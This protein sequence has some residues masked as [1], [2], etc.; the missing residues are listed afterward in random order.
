MLK[1]TDTEF[2]SLNK[3]VLQNGSTAN[4]EWS[5][6]EL[7]VHLESRMCGMEELLLTLCSRL[8]AH[9]DTGDVVVKV[10][11]VQENND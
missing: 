11:H 2:A 1:I 10:N 7:L 8:Q 9:I 6:D 4:E 5:L 3:Y